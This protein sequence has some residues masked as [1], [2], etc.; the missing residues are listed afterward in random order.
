MSL[1]SDY[2][3]H[4]NRIL[5]DQ[6][7]IKPREERRSG[8]PDI[9]ISAMCCNPGSCGINY[10]ASQETAP[11]DKNNHDVEYK[12]IKAVN[13]TA[14]DHIREYKEKEERLKKELEDYEKS[15]KK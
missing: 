6:E 1:T 12:V 11:V 13:K 4:F 7:N 2:F 3:Y 9:C 8:K 15:K 14:A 10:A 5:Q